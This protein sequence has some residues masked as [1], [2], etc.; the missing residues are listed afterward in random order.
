MYD[1]MQLAR[2]QGCWLGQLTGDA[3]GSMVEFGTAASIARR[4]PDG[5]REIGPS[6]VHETIAG[7]ATDDSEMALALA[8]TL[9]RVGRYDDEAIAAAY[10]EW[11]NSPPFDIGRTT[12]WALGAL[13]EQHK[14]GLPLVDARPVIATKNAASEANGA[15]M[16]QSPLA[17]WGNALSPDALA[18]VVRRDTTLT[19]PNRVCADASCAV[20]LP[21]ARVIREGLDAEAA[22]AFAC[23]WDAIHGHSPAV[24]ET[25]H[26]A[27]AAP[28][29]YGH[30]A[31]HVLV[32]LQNA[33]YQAL[34]ASSLEDGIVA[35]VMGGHDSDT[36]AAIAGALLG[37]IHGVD[38]VPA[39]WRDAVLTCRPSA[40]IP[41]SRHP[42][43]A[44]YWP[45]DALD[46]AGA[47]LNMA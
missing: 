43:P 29:D 25:L 24:T 28:P 14:R 19:H 26:A 2:A 38:A 45:A 11:Y 9:I 27:H 47:L 7:Q 1:T 40:D 35:T 5:L 37:A 13:H 8:R 46:L 33:W 6:G 39:Q 30:N 32:A 21:M 42:R 20:I 22:Y 4:Y 18:D 15:L 36:N 23:E 10:L 3:L 31:G 17:V 12:L 41:G 44:T 34:H 16:R